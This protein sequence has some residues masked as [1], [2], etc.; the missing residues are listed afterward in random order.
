[1]AVLQSLNA[2]LAAPLALAILNAAFDTHWP[3]LLAKLGAVPGPTSETKTPERSD[4]DMLEEVVGLC[5]QIAAIDRS[6]VPLPESMSWG[7]VLD[8]INSG[9]MHTANHRN[10]LRGRAATARVRADESK[11]D[12]TDFAAIKDAFRCADVE[13][14]RFRK[15]VSTAVY[16]VAYS[17]K[18]SGFDTEAATDKALDAIREYMKIHDVISPAEAKKLAEDSV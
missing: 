4:R 18:I 10:F 13:T 8:A 2:S 14:P 16:G 17:E 1:L 6:Q 12:P 7:A 5:R 9:S 3:K 11:D 15:A